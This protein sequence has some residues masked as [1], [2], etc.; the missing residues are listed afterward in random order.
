MTTE[1]SDKT[2]L[3]R[4]TELFMEVRDRDT[5][6][7]DDLKEEINELEASRDHYQEERRHYVDKYLR[8]SNR[9]E[10]WR[11]IN[12]ALVAGAF[13]YHLRDIITWAGMVTTQ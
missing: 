4:A 5:R 6:Y 13:I 1:A 9:A 7:I 11:F 3:Y 8:S 2:V 12:F 10:W